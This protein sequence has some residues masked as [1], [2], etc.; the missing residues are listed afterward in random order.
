MKN[1]FSLLFVVFAFMLVGCGEHFFNDIWEQVKD[2]IMPEALKGE[3]TRGIV[4][5][6][7]IPSA[8]RSDFERA[9]PV[10]SG[11]KPPDIKGQY[12]SNHLT[13]TGSTLSEDDDY[14]GST[15]WSDVYVAFIEGS[16]S[17]LSYKER[18]SS[19][20]AASETLDVVGS[21]N[22]FTAYF[23]SEGTTHGIRYKQSTVISG[24]LT[25]SGISDFH[26]SFVML[27]KGPDP[28]E[29]IV[30]INTYRIFKDGDGLAER[31]TWLQQ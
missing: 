4:P 18:Q 21:G 20:Q 31:H 12:L 17:T 23:I 19:E 22:D 10:H 25:S 24:T 9:M 26:Y 6:S 11:T 15:L 16:K 13:L 30:P 1:R 14:I 27:E 5:Y 3:L 28:E 2:S 29:I 7:V 8:I